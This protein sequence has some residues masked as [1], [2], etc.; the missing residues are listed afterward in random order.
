MSTNESAS[1]PNGTQT[2]HVK[3]RA[4]NV[5]PRSSL[6]VDSLAMSRPFARSSC[7]VGTMLGTRP[8]AA[9]SNSVSP[10]AYTKDDEP[11]HCER[12]AAHRYG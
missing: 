10:H 11:D 5:G 9:G 6:A 12:A 3:S 2:A 4:P 8:A 7:A 1:I